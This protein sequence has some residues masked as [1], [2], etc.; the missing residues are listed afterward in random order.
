MTAEEVVVNLIKLNHGQLT[1]RTR[2]QKEA[3]LLDRCGGK[4]GLRFTYHHY[5][6]YSFELAEGWEDAQAA[7]RIDI[8]ER[9]GRYDVPYSVFT[10]R[11]PVG[12]PDRLGDLSAID[13]RERLQKMASVSDIVLELAA[14]IIYL[15]EEG[16]AEQTIKE[17]KTRKPL[18]ATDQLVAKASSLLVSLGF[19][20]NRSL[21]G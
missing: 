11:G 3:Y 6:P 8:V 21:Q 17:L 20:G 1:G 13:A 18:K 2:L 14:S 19:E 5:G 9:P 4:F 7:E 15:E 10:V 16:Y 12:A